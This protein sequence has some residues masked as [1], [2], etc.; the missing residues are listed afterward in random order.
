MTKKQAVSDDTSS[1]KTSVQSKKE[2][3]EEESK[4]DVVTLARSIKS[5]ISSQQELLNRLSTDLDKIN[6]N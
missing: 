3:S 5:F 1:V 4:D 2:S 6:E